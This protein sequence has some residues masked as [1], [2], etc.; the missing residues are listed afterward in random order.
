MDVTDAASTW[1]GTRHTVVASIRRS[2]KKLV[3]CRKLT[4]LLAGNGLSVD[5]LQA[6]HIGLKPTKYRS[7]YLRANLQRNI[8]FGRQVQALQIKCG[9]PHGCKYRY[10]GG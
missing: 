4:L 8:R 10:S 3:E 1:A 9:N 7:Q 2:R 6:E 5:L